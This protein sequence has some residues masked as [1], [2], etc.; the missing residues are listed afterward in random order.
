MTNTVNSFES[1]LYY[2]LV[3]SRFQQVET[4]VARNAIEHSET[5]EVYFKAA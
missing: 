3:E 1:R 2:I 5:N 4:F